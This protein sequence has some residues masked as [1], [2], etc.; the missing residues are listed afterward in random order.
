M[1]AETCGP[2]FMNTGYFCKRWVSAPTLWLDPVHKSSPRGIDIVF[3]PT[4]SL[5]R[6]G[7]VIYKQT[8]HSCIKLKLHTSFI[9]RK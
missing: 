8:K 1:K 5:R 4:Q 3:E 2:A 9:K 7:A 6:I